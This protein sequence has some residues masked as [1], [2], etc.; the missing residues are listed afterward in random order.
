MLFIL[1]AYAVNIYLINI[2]ANSVLSSQEELGRESTGKHQSRLP[3]IRT[4]ETISQLYKL[5]DLIIN[6]LAK[7]GQYRNN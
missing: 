7:L 5:S 3:C 6:S 2:L 1:S 4:R